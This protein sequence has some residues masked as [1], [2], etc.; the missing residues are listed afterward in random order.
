MGFR[1]VNCVELGLQEQLEQAATAND[2]V[3]AFA[4]AR[5]FEKSIEEIFEDGTEPRAKLAAE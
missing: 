5:L 3:L 1:S 2:D 4:I